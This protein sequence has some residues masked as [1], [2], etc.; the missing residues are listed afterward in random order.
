MSIDWC[1]DWKFFFSLS[2]IRCRVCPYVVW[3]KN[4]I[5]NCQK[6]SHS[7]ELICCGILRSTCTVDGW[8]LLKIVDYRNVQFIGNEWINVRS[9]NNTGKKKHIVINAQSSCREIGFIVCWKF[10]VRWLFCTF[11]LFVS[12]ARV[13]VRLC[14]CCVYFS[15]RWECV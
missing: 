4:E 2:R 5:R 7:C 11:C 6:K 10:S 1:L 15:M 14:L 9:E 13:W 12:S 8:M 3:C